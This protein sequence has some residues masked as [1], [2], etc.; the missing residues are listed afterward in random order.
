MA[1]LRFAHTSAEEQETL[2]KLNSNQ[3]LKQTR[4]P[5]KNDKENLKGEN[6]NF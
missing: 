5:K 4:L 2:L 3:T 6:D 1:A